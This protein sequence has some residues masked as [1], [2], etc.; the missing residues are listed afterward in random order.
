MGSEMCIR[1]RDFGDG[2]MLTSQSGDVDH[3][4]EVSG[5]YD[6]SLTVENMHGMFSD[7]Y[8]EAITVQAAMVG[9]LTQDGNI[10]VLDIVSMVNLV[11]GEQPVG[12]QLFIGDINT[13]G[14]INIQDIILLIGLAL[15][16]Q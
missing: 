2:N 12:S 4:F 8:T 1:D 3:S 14:I 6:V 11:L 5:T 7:P 9:D 10:D 15:N 13:D 16:G